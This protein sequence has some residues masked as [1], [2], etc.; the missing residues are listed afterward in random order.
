MQTIFWMWDERTCDDDD[1]MCDM[2]ETFFL[3]VAL[4]LIDQ[5]HKTLGEDFKQLRECFDSM[6]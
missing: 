5:F 6:L 4:L 1:A 2:H 3:H